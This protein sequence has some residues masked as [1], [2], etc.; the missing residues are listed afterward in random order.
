[1]WG[2][3]G[4]RAADVRVEG[5]RVAEVGALTP[6][7]GEE[8]VDAGGLDVLPG[9]ID[10]HVHADDRIGG[11]DL[12]DTWASASGIAVRHGITTLAGFATQGAGESV[13]AALGRC[14]GRAAGRSHCDFTFHLTP[15]AWPW[16]GAD[17]DGLVAAGFST[18][19]LYT[20]YRDAGLFTGYPR[21]REVMGRLV[22]LGARL[23]VHCEDDG[24]LAR[25]DG[26]ALDPADARGHGRLRPEAAEAAAIREVL[27]LAEATG[28]PVHVV[29]V[30][31][32]EGA[33]TVRAARAGGVPVTCETA[34]HYLVLDESSLAGPSG[35]RFLCTPPLRAAAT[36]S[37]MEDLAAEGTFD[38]LATDHCAFS[39]AD[40]DARAGDFRS[41]PKGIA[42]LGALVPLAFDQ[43][44]RRRGQPLSALVRLLSA[45]PARLLGAYPRKGVIV[46]GADADLVLL[47]RDGPERPLTSTLAD[48]HETYPGRTTRLAL[49]GVFLRGREVV[50]DGAV[51]APHA[52]GRCLASA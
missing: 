10:V 25:V 35:H 23:L 29:H 2:E 37:R 16:E 4:G 20:T 7:P 19:K 17:V 41:V 38:L 39:R 44:V 26:S 24:V 32:A 11:V 42:G 34:P 43:L 1:V 48:C 18:F 22:P 12:A 52:G 6:R 3:D 14:L 27:S 21:L 30:S 46:V 5:E 50:R 51:V 15:T 31:T 33:E 45:N 49:R 9:M 47:A 13:A 36:R 28:C 40:K 8:V